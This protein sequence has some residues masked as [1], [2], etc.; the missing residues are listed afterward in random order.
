VEA[1]KVAVTG[2]LL[3][4]LFV[5]IPLVTKWLYTLNESRYGRVPRLAPAVVLFVLSVEL[6]VLGMLSGVSGYFRWPPFDSGKWISIQLWLGVIGAFATFAS[7]AFIR[8]GLIAN[9]PRL[10]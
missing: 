7:I 8:S 4:F 3:L 5:A 10:E 9:E 6:A 2:I 1:I